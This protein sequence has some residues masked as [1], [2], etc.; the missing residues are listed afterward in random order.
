MNDDDLPSAER[1][2]FENLTTFLR[3]PGSRYQRFKKLEILQDQLNAIRDFVI[4][5]NAY[6]YK[7]ALL[8]GVYFLEDCICV[9][10]RKLSQLLGKSK[11]SINTSLSE[12]GYNRNL[13][14]NEEQ[15]KLFEALPQLKHML[16]ESKQWTIRA[17]EPTKAPNPEISVPSQCCYGCMCGCTC[18]PDDEVLNC[19]CRSCGGCPCGKRFWES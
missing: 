17:K 6:D 4:K 12:L 7:R 1:E 5:H 8:C 3:N 9:N 15:M 2:R 19:S 14:S 10:N 16:D 11:S 18:K 13:S